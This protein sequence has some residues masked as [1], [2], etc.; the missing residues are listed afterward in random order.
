MD[1]SN[2]SRVQEALLHLYLRL[3]G[4]FVSSL[5]VH[6]KEY[7]KIDAQID[8]VAVRHP[9]HRQPERQVGPSPFLHPTGTDLLICE[10]KSYG[11]QLQFNEPLR[12]DAA[13]I[14]SALRW[15]GLF[16]EEETT[17]VG[18]ELQ[19]ILQPSTPADKGETGI[20]GVGG[21]TVRPLLCSP[22]QRHSRP[23]QPWFAC[24]EEI[25][26]YIAKCVN[27]ATQRKD[28]STRYDIT[29][30]GLSLTPTIKYFKQRP[31]GDAGEMKDLYEFLKAR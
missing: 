13:V 8:A 1:E 21:V 6:S 11:Q 15:A 17:R 14:Q 18:R 19:S 22:E 24:G 30:W 7:G 29:A 27:P 31:A 9:L 26:S 28:C 25:F 16:D 23:N 12:E 3:N 4:Y 20:P 2:R 5:I 10:V